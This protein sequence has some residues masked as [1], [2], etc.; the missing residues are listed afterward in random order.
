MQ[1]SLQPRLLFIRVKMRDRQLALFCKLDVVLEFQ[2]WF[3]AIFQH[4]D[5][6]ST[7]STSML[8]RSFQVAL[9]IQFRFSCQLFLNHLLSKTC[10]LQKKWCTYYILTSPAPV[11][12]WYRSSSRLHFLDYCMSHFCKLF[13]SFLHH[14]HQ[15][16]STMFSCNRHKSAKI[17][18]KS[19]R[20]R[21][22]R[23]NHN[24]LFSN[25]TDN[26]FAHFYSAQNAPVFR[27]RIFYCLYK[28]IYEKILK[29]LPYKEV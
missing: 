8:D 5:L 17:T 21:K 14:I 7:P 29:W 12:F 6:I 23:Q 28:K 16:Q 3:L 25:A 18:K 11:C 19:Q 26:M 13:F 20:T 15:W 9:H 24:L 10:T 4:C 22:T 2:D 1:F 27:W